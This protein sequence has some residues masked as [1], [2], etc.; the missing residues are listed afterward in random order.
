MQTLEV[1][2]C[3][4]SISSGTFRVSPIYSYSL[5]GLDPGITIVCID[6]IQ[7][8]GLIIA[9]TH[10]YIEVA[11]QFI[12]QCACT[13]MFTVVNNPV[14]Q[15][16]HAS[17]VHLDRGVVERILGIRRRGYCR[18]SGFNT[19]LYTRRNCG[20]RIVVIFCV[21]NGT[22]TQSACSKLSKYIFISRAVFYSNSTG[23][24]G[25]RIEFNDVVHEH[26]IL[27]S[28]I[29][30]ITDYGFPV[31]HELYTHFILPVVYRIHVVQILIVGSLAC[32]FNSPGFIYC[33]FIASAENLRACESQVFRI[34]SLRCL[35]NEHRS[36]KG[37]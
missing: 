2:Q 36:G 32:L 5:I 29:E 3:E 8:L 4:I 27:H 26:F 16:S 21:V 34:H 20:N 12:N 18:S 28:R 11:F 17:W 23:L 10:G 13:I 6:Q 37:I 19:F 35:Y 14:K 7:V 22:H 1:V 15:Q 31:P 9:F 33:I 25:A 30:L 24:H